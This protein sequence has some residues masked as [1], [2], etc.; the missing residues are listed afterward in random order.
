[1]DELHSIVSE[2]TLWAARKAVLDCDFPNGDCEIEGATV[3][4][5]TPHKYPPFAGSTDYYISTQPSS[6]CPAV[7]QS[8][9]SRRLCYCKAP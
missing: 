1:V 5:H 8:N 2:D 4:V 9:V 6:T 3:Y 7:S